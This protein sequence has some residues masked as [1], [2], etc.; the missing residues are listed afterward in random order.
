MSPAQ[1]GRDGEHDPVGYRERR[2]HL[3]ADPAIPGE[4]LDQGTVRVDLQRLDR[5][6][7][8][9]PGDRAGPGYVHRTWFGVVSLGPA[10]DLADQPVM[11]AEPDADLIGARRRDRPVRLQHRVL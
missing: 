2:P 8:V 6:G 9:E 1:P 11:A 4:P 3:G 5:L 7:D 10:V